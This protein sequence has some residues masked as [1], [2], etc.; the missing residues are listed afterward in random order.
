MLHFVAE[1][2]RQ[3]GQ[4]YPPKTIHQILAGLQR[5]MLDKNPLAPKFLDLVQKNPISHGIHRACDCVYRK[6][7]QQGVVTQVRHA[8]IIP[9][10]EEEKLW[11]TG[12]L[13]HKSLH[14]AVFYY[15]GKCLV[16][17]MEVKNRGDC[18]HR[19]SKGQVIL[20][21][22]LVLHTDLRTIQV[23]WNSYLWGTKGFHFQLF[24]KISCRVSSFFWTS[25]S[26]GCRSTR[27]SRISFAWDQSHPSLPMMMNHGM[28]VLPLA[29]TVWQACWRK[30]AKKLALK[31]KL[32]IVCEQPERCL[33][34]RLMFQSKSSRKNW[35]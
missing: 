27:L 5:Y 30:C 22:M 17:F 23:V 28:S 35:T 16:V 21:A 12:N 24:Q 29:R 8:A 32:I 31:R 33:C 2:W 26:E 25:I 20:T 15:V 1:V 14:R 7:Q 18:A 10:T 13:T 11:V 3:D 6:L 19:C 4:P 34:S 9:E